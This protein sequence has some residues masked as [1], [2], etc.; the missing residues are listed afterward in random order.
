VQ[1]DVGYRRAALI[2]SGEDIVIPRF[3][4]PV[5][6]EA[7]GPVTEKGEERQEERAL[8]VRA[9]LHAGNDISERTLAE[10]RPPRCAREV[11]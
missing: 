10:D 6:Y 8:R 1:P 3:A 11:V 9:R 2:G 7:T 4:G 5:E